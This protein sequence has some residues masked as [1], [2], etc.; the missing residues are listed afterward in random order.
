MLLL[1]FALIIE[2]TSYRIHEV[3]W[4]RFTKT[5]IKLRFVKTIVIFVLREN[6][7]STFDKE[8]D[9]LKNAILKTAHPLPFS[10]NKGLFGNHFKIINSIIDIL[11]D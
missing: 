3:L 6:I 10:A 2:S 5:C 8:I 1:N 11:I 9:M 7:A 4:H